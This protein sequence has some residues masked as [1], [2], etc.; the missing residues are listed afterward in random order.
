MGRGWVRLYEILRRRKAEDLLVEQVARLCAHPSARGRRGAGERLDDGCCFA[1]HFAPCL[2]L[3]Q[4]ESL[5]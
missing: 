3:S 4:H 1:S 5:F 2:P